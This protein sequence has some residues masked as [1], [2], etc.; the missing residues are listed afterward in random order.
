MK[1]C[2]F[3]QQQK[4]SIFSKAEHKLKMLNILSGGTHITRVHDNIMV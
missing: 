4:E 2:D 1:R 3:L